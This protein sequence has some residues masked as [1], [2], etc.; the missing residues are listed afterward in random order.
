MKVSVFGPRELTQKQQENIKYFW[1]LFKAKRSDIVFIHGGSKGLQ[2][3]ILDI[4]N[5]EYA[6][7]PIIL[8]K[9]WNIVDKGIEYSIKL[10]FN[11]NKQ[12]MDNSDVVLLFELETDAKLSWMTEYCDKHNINYMTIKGNENE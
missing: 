5:K 7:T 4:E 11:R 9:P 10:M 3:F 8:F 2:K 12:I 1:T 6:G